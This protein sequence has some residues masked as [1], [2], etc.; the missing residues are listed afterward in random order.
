MKRLTAFLL[1]GIMCFSGFSCANADEAQETQEYEKVLFSETFDE[2][3]D[4][5]LTLAYGDS[6]N[7]MLPEEVSNERVIV[8]FDMKIDTGYIGYVYLARIIASES[9]QNFLWMEWNQIM[10]NKGGLNN[11]F[12]SVKSFADFKNI[13]VTLNLKNKKIESVYF[14][15]QKMTN[16]YLPDISYNKI[17]GFN[18][19]NKSQKQ[20]PR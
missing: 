9:Y 3:E 12:A 20:K 4:G 8:S 5:C 13:E 19:Q 14:D 17:T 11:Y 18:F 15:G 6:K 7:V 16:G 2:E 1:T 10:V